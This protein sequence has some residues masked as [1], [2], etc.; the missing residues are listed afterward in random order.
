L[1]S[2]SAVAG[3]SILCN[4]LERLHKHRAFI[5]LMARIVTQ[6]TLSAFGGAFICIPQSLKLAIM[7]AFLYVCGADLQMRHLVRPK[8]L[9]SGRECPFARGRPLGGP[10]T[11]RISPSTATVHD[12]NTSSNRVL[13]SLNS[14]RLSPPFR[15]ICFTRCSKVTLSLLWLASNSEDAC[16]SA[17]GNEVISSSSDV[18]SSDYS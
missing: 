14:S 1:S 15:A 8:R 11:S 7:N 13:V 6:Q 2:H 18:S 4:R 5:P 16:V 12:C 17:G 3:A 9:E 10:I